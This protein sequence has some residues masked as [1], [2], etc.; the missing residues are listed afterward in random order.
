MNAGELDVILQDLS[1][2]NNA[3][4][5]A[6]EE[7]LK[8]WDNDPQIVLLLLTCIDS[9]AYSPATEATQTLCCVLLSW[10]LPQL[11]SRLS[12]EEQTRVR[13]HILAQITLHTTGPVLRT[14]AELAQTVA[15]SCAAE[16]CEWPELLHGVLSLTGRESE[17]HRCLGFTL[18]N[19]LLDSLGGR[20]V[21]IF[22][23]LVEVVQRAVL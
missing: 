5:A 19:S 11:W 23:N 16:G 3:R 18:A 14:L 21:Q 1:A 7:R 8:Q 20:M 17:V 2:N 12:L 22:P 6:A 13:E 15:Q 9:S 4:R 10:R